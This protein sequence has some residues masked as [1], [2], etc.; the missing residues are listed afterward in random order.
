MQWI[1]LSQERL[2]FCA[3]VSKINNWWFLEKRGNFLIS[4]TTPGLR[5]KLSHMEGAYFSNSQD[6]V[7]AIESANSVYMVLFI[8]DFI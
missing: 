2:H 1:S 3:I 8:S 4:W 7:R 6:C 5:I